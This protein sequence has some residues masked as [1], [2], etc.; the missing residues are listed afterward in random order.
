MIAVVARRGADF[1]VSRIRSGASSLMI[2][3]WRGNLVC[4]R[5]LRREGLI[6]SVFAGLC[7]MI[8]PLKFKKMQ[9]HNLLWWVGGMK[10]RAN[11]H[12]LSFLQAPKLHP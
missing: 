4:D 9:S 10:I 5:I 3:I 12:P 6:R 11:S 1:Q 2:A 7:C 8:S